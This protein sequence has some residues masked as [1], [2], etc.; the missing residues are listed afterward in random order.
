MWII[1]FVYQ[2][3]LRKTENTILN[4]YLESPS[5]SFRLKTFCPQ[6]YGVMGLVYI[7]Y[8][9]IWLCMLACNW[10]DLLRVQFWVGGVIFLGNCQGFQI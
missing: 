10:K 2:L 3:A 1:Y 7:A 8:G 5:Y 9:L 6:F 4:I